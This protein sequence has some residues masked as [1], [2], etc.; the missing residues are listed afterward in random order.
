MFN[1]VLKRARKT[2]FVLTILTLSASAVLYSQ[3]TLGTPLN[4]VDEGTSFRV[5][6]DI[7]LPRQSEVLIARKSVTSDKSKRKSISKEKL[8]YLVRNEYQPEANI[9]REGTILTMVDR[10]WNFK[11]S[12][13]PNNTIKLACYQ[14]VITRAYV[15]DYDRCYPWPRGCDS[16]KAWQWVSHESVERFTTIEE[17][18]ELL[19][20]T[21]Q[22]EDLKL[23][24]DF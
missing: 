13:N 6:K 8:C 7:L 16:H 17:V 15:Y 18:V 20:G 1:L 24:D 21:F 11:S 14:R 2:K 22:L 5:L 19:E 9:L 3:T 12:H 10:H 4:S 23:G